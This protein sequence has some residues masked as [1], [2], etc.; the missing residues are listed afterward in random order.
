M[1]PWLTLSL[2]FQLADAGLLPEHLRMSWVP[3]SGIATKCPCDNASLCKTP[4]VQHKRE[5]FGF[6]GARW[7]DFDW[8]QVTTVAWADNAE[9]ICT[10]HASGARRIAAAPELVF[11][12]NRKERRK[13]IDRLIGTMKR[14]FYDGVTFDYENPLDKTPGSSTFEKQEQYVALIKETTEQLHA[15]IPGSQTSVCVAWSPDDID[16]RNYDYVALV[17][18]ADLAYVMM[19]DTRSQIYGKC[20]ASANSPLGITERGLIR[21][22]DLGIP[23]EK[24]VLGTPWYGYVYPCLNAEP[25]DD[26]CEIKLVP[27]RG[28]NCSDAAGWEVPFMNIMDLLDRNI[29]PGGIPAGST[30]EVTTSLTWDE[31]TQSPFFNFVV[32]SS[33]VHQVWFDD[34]RSSAIK[35]GLAKNMGLRGVGPY[36]WSDL[37]ANGSVTGNPRAAAESKAM[38]D[39]LRTFSERTTAREYRMQVVL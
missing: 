38:W 18:A 30:C 27:F 23:P 10:A 7:Q 39:A 36:T 8:S 13:W 26:V 12:S 1:S 19:Y 2:L 21:Y 24:L 17:A 28:V 16:G 5:L 4:T 22:L 6:S 32:N 37:D 29:C 9:M 35:Y 33:K 14:D 25:Q 11:S 31:S 3:A 20:V 34:A 15:A